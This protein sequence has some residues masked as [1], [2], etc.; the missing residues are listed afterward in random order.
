M[1]CL[2]KL[3][4]RD[5]TD[6]RRTVEV[7]AMTAV[8]TENVVELDAPDGATAS[9]REKTA[10]RLLASS[11]RHSYNPDLDIDWSSGPVDGLWHMQPERMT[12]YGTP[13]W[14]SLTD[15]QRIELS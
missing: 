13:L 8:L 9:E 6:T 4:R 1:S 11:A 2:Q 7:A 15:E 5:V 12:L 10:R 14:E 3:A